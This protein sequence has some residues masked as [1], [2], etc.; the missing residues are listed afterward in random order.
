MSLEAGCEESTPVTDL[1]ESFML[2]IAPATLPEPFWDR[3][4]PEEAASDLETPDA[5]CFPAWALPFFLAC[6]FL[7]AS[8]GIISNS[9]CN[10]M[11]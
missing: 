2:A 6:R 5:A 9:T 1:A 3:L 4:G 7:A 11:Y 10:S 8:V